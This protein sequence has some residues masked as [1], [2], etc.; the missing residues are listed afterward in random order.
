MPA[1]FPCLRERHRELIAAQRVFFIATAA[2]TGR[3]NLSPKGMDTLRVLDDTTVAYLDLTGSGNETAAHLLADGRCTLMFCSFDEDPTIL[4]IYGRG[5]A[6]GAADPRWE[7]LRARFP[8]L[9]GVR[10]IMRIEVESVQTSCGYAVPIA[11]AMRPRE[12]LV[13]WLERKGPEELARYRSRKNRQS[14]DG[15][16][17]GLP[18]DDDAEDEA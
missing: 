7:E 11:D 13:R 1:F 9:P 4:R 14:I 16:P 10:Q 6:I 18:A 15:F 8:D 17:T 5:E 3:I 12:R 2:S